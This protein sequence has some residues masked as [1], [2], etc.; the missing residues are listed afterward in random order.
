M[1]PVGNLEV[2]GG[3]MDLRTNYREDYLRPSISSTKPEKKIPTEQKVYA[4]PPMRGISQTSFDYR[5][6]PE[7]RPPP[8]AYIE[9]FHSQISLGNNNTN[10]SSLVSLAC[11]VFLH[12]LKKNYFYSRD[13][14]YRVDYPGYDTTQHPR[15]AAAMPKEERRIYTGPNEKMDTQTIT[16]VDFIIFRSIESIG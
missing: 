1:E 9:R 11:F 12:S 6:Y 5:A 16:Q 7:H 2:S 14:Q 8:L 15:P 10:A 3:S 4:K 13:S